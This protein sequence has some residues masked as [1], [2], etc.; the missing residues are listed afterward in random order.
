MKSTSKKQFLIEFDK[1]LMNRVN[2]IRY[3][4]ESLP[5]LLRKGK[6]EHCLAAYTVFIKNPK[7]YEYTENQKIRILDAFNARW[8]IA[9]KNSK[10]SIAIILYQI[11]ECRE[12]IKSFNK[13]NAQ[14]TKQE[15]TELTESIESVDQSLEQS[16]DLVSESTEEDLEE[17]HIELEDL[18]DELPNT[19]RIL[20]T[21]S[22]KAEQAV[23][24]LV[25]GIDKLINRIAQIKTNREFPEKFNDLTQSLLQAIVS[26][27]KNDVKKLTK[28]LEQ[29]IANTS[30]KKALKDQGKR[31][32][33]I[34][35]AKNDTPINQQKVFASIIKKMDVK[36]NKLEP[37]VKK[38]FSEAAKEAKKE[39]SEQR[40]KNREDAREKLKELK[41]EEKY[42]KKHGFRSL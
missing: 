12:K 21:L 6:I 27:N 35:I 36:V 31:L 17:L 4:T 14:A 5:E 9:S 16:E 11:N 37:K 22:I 24:K 29:L 32:F 8:E 18:L 26:D 28:E 38:A 7:S 3:I 23:R 2:N 15:I 25:G 40:K 30:N 33:N 10:E 19:K 1:L 39:R 41:A 13:K 20:L 42:E 34:F